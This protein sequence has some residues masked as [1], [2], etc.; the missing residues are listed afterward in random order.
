MEKKDFRPYLSADEYVVWQ[1]RPEGKSLFRREDMLTIPFGVF[2]LLFACIWAAAAAQGSPIFALFA[3]PFIGTG[4]YFT[5]GMVF[6]RAH[7]LSKTEYAVTNKRL[8]RING[9]KVDIV[10]G[11]QIQNLEITMNTDGTGTITFLRPQPQY[12][13]GRNQ[14]LSPGVLFAF[15]SLDNIKDVIHVQQKIN[16]IEK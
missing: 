16:E 9:T 14:S 10:Y 5:V 4:L 8:I 13:G 3:I 1:G 11:S 7:I 2:F 6:H 12:Y 15:R